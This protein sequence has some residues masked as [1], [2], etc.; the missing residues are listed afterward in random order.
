MD[1]NSNNDGDNALDVVSDQDTLILQGTRSD[2]G[3]VQNDDDTFTIS[4][5]IEG[6]DGTETI[7]GFDKIEFSDVQMSMTE[8]LA[9]AQINAARAIESD[10]MMAMGQSIGGLST[11]GWAENVEDHDIDAT[12]FNAWDN[13]MDAQDEIA[14]AAGALEI[15]ADTNGS[16]ALANA[17][18]LD[19]LA[20]L[21]DPANF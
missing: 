19:S 5:K 3:I 13:D 7:A 9:T 10:T 4:D 2:Y 18:E 6:R 21:G 11:D 14:L 17:T 16:I 1:S 12:A 15:G 20:T 8:A